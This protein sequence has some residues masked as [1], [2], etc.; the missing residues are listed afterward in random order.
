[1]SEK[2][3]VLQA[4]VNTGLRRGIYVRARVRQ[5]VKELDQPTDS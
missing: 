5:Q 2:H 3:Q 1:M 4:R